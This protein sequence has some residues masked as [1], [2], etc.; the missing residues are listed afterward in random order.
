MPTK[1]TKKELT[2]KQLAALAAGRA[3]PNG[4]FKKG[5][6]RQKAGIQARKE[7]AAQRK[8]WREAKQFA[9]ARKLKR[10]I[11]IGNGNFLLTGYETEND[12]NRAERDVKRV[13]SLLSES[14]LYEI[15]KMLAPYR[16]EAAR[17][18]DELNALNEGG[19]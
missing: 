9:A 4:R 15:T 11:E 12:L 6:E 3:N 17:I 14:S 16:E 5:D 2:E 7:K 10:G 1:K 8:K 13:L 19:G 18:E